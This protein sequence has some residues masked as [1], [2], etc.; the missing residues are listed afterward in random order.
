MNNPLRYSGTTFYQQSYNT[1]ALGKPTGTILQV[2]TNPS[3]MT[4][5]VACM[6]VGIGMLAHFGT[7]L[8]RFLRRRT[9]ET[10]ELVTSSAV[11]TP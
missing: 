11:T 9:D 3:W 6:L 10:E 5:Y 7:M 1:D 8:F 4:P 2:V